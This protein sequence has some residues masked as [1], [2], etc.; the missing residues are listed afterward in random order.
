MP[1]AGEAAGVET[2]GLASSSAVCVAGGVHEMISSMSPSVLKIYFVTLT[3]FRTVRLACL[4]IDFHRLLILT[5]H[6][7]QSEG[8]AFQFI[9]TQ[10]CSWRGQDFDDAGFF[11]KVRFCLLRKLQHTLLARTDLQPLCTCFIFLY[12]YL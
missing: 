7:K 3:A 2:F 10:D 9:P 5:G 11:S 8:C 1:A 6:M 4:P 12:I